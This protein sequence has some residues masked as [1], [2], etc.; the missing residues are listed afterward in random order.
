M[1]GKSTS[2]FAVNYLSIWLKKYLIGSSCDKKQSSLSTHTNHLQ[3]RFAV[4]ICFGLLSTLD[5]LC[6][7]DGKESGGTAGDLSSIPGLGRSPGEGHG[8]PLRYSCL[9]N[10]RGLRSLVGYS[11]WGRKESDIIE[12]R[13]TLR[14]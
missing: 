2:G 8:N 3:L 9:E 6:G 10:P 7:P 14:H 12:Q 1:D 11:P 13:T 4:Y 5:F